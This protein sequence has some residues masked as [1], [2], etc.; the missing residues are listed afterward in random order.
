MGQTYSMILVTEMIS[1][2]AATVRFKP[3]YGCGTSSMQSLN[4]WQ[5]WHPQ[6]QDLPGMS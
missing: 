3:G 4:S 2:L 6:P 5:S 1:V